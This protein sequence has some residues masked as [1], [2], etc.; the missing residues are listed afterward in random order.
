MIHESRH[1]Y[2]ATH[3]PAPLIHFLALHCLLCSR[4]LLHSFVC[5]LAHSLTSKLVGKCMIRC[6]KTTWFYP[7]VCQSRVT[8]K[9]AR[10]RVPP[11]LALRAESRGKETHH[12]LIALEVMAI[13]SMKLGES[14]DSK[15]DVRVEKEGRHCGPEYPRIQTAILGHSLVR[16]L[17]AHTTHLF[18]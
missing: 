4:T 16:S 12:D 17:L 8:G 11:A 14:V 6:L 3:S 2:W 7:I 18:A 15:G 9:E 5:S 13:A 1:K 10:D